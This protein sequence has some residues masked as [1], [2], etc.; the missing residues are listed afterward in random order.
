MPLKTS[1]GGRNDFKCTLNRTWWQLLSQRLNLPLS[2]QEKGERAD[3]NPQEGGAKARNNN[4]ARA[5]RLSFL[6][7]DGVPAKE[8]EGKGETKL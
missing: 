3:D 7:F 2:L 6:D 8:G 1:L 4:L 5:R